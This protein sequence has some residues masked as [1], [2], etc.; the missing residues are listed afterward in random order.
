MEIRRV[1]IES[2]FRSTD[3]GI[4]RNINYAKKCIL[5][6]L[7]INEAPLTSHLLY[8]RIGILE[9][10]D[11]D[12]R[13]KGIAAGHAWIPVADAVIVYEDFGISDGMKKGIEVAEE[14]GI[15]I[16]YRKIL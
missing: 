15:P 8:T 3:A 12:E 10:N 5:H 16:E 11:E 14:F 13:K 1:V 4:Y 9:D 2:P 6:S 7:S